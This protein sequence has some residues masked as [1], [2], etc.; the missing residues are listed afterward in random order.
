M[1]DKSRPW[2]R[3]DHCA[4]RREAID[5]AAAA[6]RAAALEATEETEEEVEEPCKS[7]TPQRD[8]RANTTN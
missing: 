2:R 8:T 3:T 5:R 6:A 4:L 7:T 1:T